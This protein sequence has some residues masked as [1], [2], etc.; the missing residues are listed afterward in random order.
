[1][2]KLECEKLAQRLACQ[3]LAQKFSTNL[4]REKSAR[5]KWHR[6]NTKIDTKIGVLKNWR[7]IGTNLAQNL[8]RQ[9]SSQNPTHLQ[10]PR[11]RLISLFQYFPQNRRDPREQRPTKKKPIITWFP[12]QQ[13]FFNPTCQTRTN[14]P[15]SPLA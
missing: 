9:N 10:K 5:Q 2:R 11:V 14:P 3:N 7:R 13:I 4:A 15:P 6:F 8:A 1:M 12:W